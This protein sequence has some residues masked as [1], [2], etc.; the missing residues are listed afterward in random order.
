MFTIGVITSTFT[1]QSTFFIRILDY[2]ATLQIDLFTYIP[3][4]HQ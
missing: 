4:T 3:F 2:H 1:M